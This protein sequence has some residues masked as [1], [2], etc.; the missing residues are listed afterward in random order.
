SNRGRN[1]ADARHLAAAS[2]GGEKALRLP[3]VKRRRQGRA[4]D[5]V[6]RRGGGVEAGGRGE[7]VSGVRGCGGAG[8]EGGRLDRDVTVII[9]QRNLAA[10]TLACIQSLQRF[11]E[12][13]IVVVDDGSGDDS[14][15]EIRWA[16]LPNCGLIKQPPHGV[17]AAWNAGIRRAETQFVLLLNNDV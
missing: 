4:D 13:K 9:P 7:G 10:L 6:D 2:A 5:G 12:I 8:M 15:E 1:A 14:A 3:R 16:N 11:E 17:T